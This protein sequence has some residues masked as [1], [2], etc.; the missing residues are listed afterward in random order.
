MI[1]VKQFRP[2]KIL[3]HINRINLWLNNKNPAPINFEL[4]LTNVCNH[5]CKECV[6]DY[7][8]SGDKSQLSKDLAINVI[9]QLSQAGAKSVVFTGGGEPLCHPDV[10]NIVYYAKT[11]GLGIGFITN[12]ELLNIR[13]SELLIDTC[14]WVRISLDAATPEVY[15]KIHGREVTSFEKV[16]KN[17]KELT[18]VAK[19]DKVS[20]CTTGIAFLTTEYSY[21]DMG[22]AALL[23]KE[24][25]VDYLQFRPMQL[26]INGKFEYDRSDISGLIDECLSLSG[27]GYE[28][29]FSKHKYDMMKEENY[30]R[31]YDVCHGQQF[32]TVVAADGKMYVCCHLRGHGK[33][34]IG[35][36]NKNSFQHIWNSDRR[37]QVVDSID[38][39]DC[40]PLCRCNTFNQILWKIKQPI[41]HEKFL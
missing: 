15:K 9:K 20:D 17:I 16:L 18:G 31:D 23:G 8:Q 24:L 19:R 34:C 32:A 37:K 10:L 2:D 6:C 21:L 25:G 12:G 41:K 22:K 13:T 38:F 28:V 36:L 1:D 35:D 3:R 40:I 26:H 29:L 11:C 30:G 4:D 27:D 7:F 33:Y 14:S 39:N 5:K